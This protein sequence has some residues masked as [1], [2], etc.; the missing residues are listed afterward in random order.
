MNESYSSKLGRILCIQR[1]A[2]G[3]IQKRHLDRREVATRTPVH[4]LICSKT[5]KME[6]LIDKKTNKLPKFATIASLCSASY[7]SCQRRTARIRC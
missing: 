7:L 4:F 5:Y 3:S 1:C 2:S 6:N